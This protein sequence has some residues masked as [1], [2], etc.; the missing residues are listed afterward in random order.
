MTPF[1]LRQ[2]TYGVCRLVKQY[3]RGLSCLCG[4]PNG[5]DEWIE[6]GGLTFLVLIVLV[7]GRRISLLTTLRTA[8]GAEA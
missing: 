5:M 1:A 4:Y 2:R 7:S 8:E 6:L 3:N